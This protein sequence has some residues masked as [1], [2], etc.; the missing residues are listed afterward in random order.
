MVWNSYFMKSNTPLVKNGVL[1]LR[2][3]NLQDKGTILLNGEWDFFPGQFIEPN[4]MYNISSRI[5]KTSVTVPG[6]WRHSLLKDRNS[7]IGYGTYRLQILL[8]HGQNQSYRLY[9][10][11][12]ESEATVYINGKLV[13]KRGQPAK[14]EANS[15]PENFPFFVLVDKGLTKI[16]LVIHVSNFENQELGGIVKP[17]QLGL[18]QAIIKDQAITYSFQYMVAIVLLFHSIYVMIIYF[19]LFGKRNKLNLEFT[20]KKSEFLYLAAT[21]FCMSIATIV[22][23]SKI[24]LYLF[25]GITYEWWRKILLSSYTTSV[26]FLVLYLK[27][28]LPFFNRLRIFQGYIALCILYLLAMFFPFQ[29]FPISGQVLLFILLFPVVVVSIIL[30]RMVSTSQ[31]SSIYLFLSIISIG[32]SIVWGAIKNIYNLETPYYPFDLIIG[33]ICFSTYWFKQFFYVAK[34]SQEYAAKLQRIDKQ[35]DDFLANTSHELRNPLHGII[36]IAQTL[37]DKNKNSLD[38]ESLKNLQLLISVGKRMS[39]MLDD[40]LDVTRLKEGKIRL[41]TS[42]VD[43]ASIVTGVFDMLYFMKEGKQIEFVLDIP[44]NFPKVE[45][46]EHRLIQILFNLIHNAVKYSNKGKIVVSAEEQKGMAMIHVK[47]SGIGMDQQILKN[48][49]Q[50][51]EQGESSLTRI[52]GGIGLGLSI[53]KQLVELHGGTISVQT[54]L[55]EGSTFTFTVPFVKDIGNEEIFQES[56]SLHEVAVG[57]IDS[58]PK[59]YKKKENL[60]LL[61]VDDDPINVR[62]FKQILELEQYDVVTCTSGNEA[63][64]ILNKN[65]F[66]LV[67]SDVMMPKMSGYELTRTI[68]ERYS[69]SEL[70]IL[71]LTAR[72]QPEDIQTG[73]QVGANDYITKP[74]EKLVFMARVKA[75]TSIKISV[76][77]RIRMEAAWL[78]AQIQPHFLFNTLNTIE[79]LSELN[80]DKMMVLLNEFG[81]FLRASFHT[82]NLEKVI[83]LENELELVRSFLFIE[84]ERFEYRLTVEWELEEGISVQVPP[85]A[86]QTLVENAV[87]HGVLKKPQGGTVRIQVKRKQKCV[88]IRIVDN[89]VGMTKEKIQQLL[90]GRTDQMQGIGIPNTDKRLK[91]LYGQGLIITSTINQGTVVSFII[92]KE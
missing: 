34:D 19:L 29:N 36:N 49:F 69:I 63:L 21:F 4:E 79:A 17:I 83:P 9:F 41:K 7:S 86:I 57:K 10:N 22:D 80:P 89:G 16:D 53:S 27:H 44:K 74:V 77:E 43:I 5:E 47:D 66:D 76:N 20:S 3:V 64:E 6:D 42:S 90:S 48:L 24:L 40:L 38:G 2:N 13:K 31:R 78:Q 70:P 26:L 37:V 59:V 85:L 65:H 58:G 35:K 12:I 33:V 91:Q 72:S 39:A 61:I 56:Q 28:F 15:I 1:D 68:R 8:D 84:Q 51:Y 11:S 62:I 14:K 23:N 71:L 81:N 46:D 25:P 82:R 32:S 60:R 30:F 87:L 18:D 73:F 45:A 55:E 88:E 75:L 50:P 54:A 67:I 92:P 52:G